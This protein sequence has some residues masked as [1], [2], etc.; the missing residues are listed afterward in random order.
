MSRR[1]ASRNRRREE[2]R[3]NSVE[4]LF[5]SSSSSSS[6]RVLLVLLASSL[7]FSLVPVVCHAAPADASG[8]RDVLQLGD[9]LLGRKKYAEAIATYSQVVESHPKEEMGFLKRS[10][11]YRRARKPDQA[12]ADL[13]AA[14]KLNGKSKQALLKRAQLYRSMCKV[15]EARGDLDALLGIKAKHKT[16]IEE[17]KRLDGLATS[18]AAL[19]KLFEARRDFHGDGFLEA[20]EQH[21]DTVFRETEFCTKAYIWYARV[22]EMKQDYEQVIRETN[23]VLQY[24]SSNIESL[25]MKA[26][27]HYQQEMFDAC[28]QTIAQIFRTDPDNE[29][30]KLLFKLVKK[31]AKI[32]SKADQLAGEKKMRQA[33]GEYRKL[34]EMGGDLNNRDI[35]KS[36]IKTLCISNHEVGKY[37]EA[38]KWC[39]RGLKTVLQEDVALLEARAESYLQQDDFDNAEYDARHILNINRHSRKAHGLIQQIQRLRKMAS[40]KDYYK[41]LEV[42]KDATESDIKKS[43][44]RLARKWHPD[45]NRD[46]VEEAQNMFHDV[47]EAYEILSDPEKKQLFDMGHDPNDPQARARNNYGFNGGGPFG[48]GGGPFGGGGQQHFHFTYG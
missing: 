6:T 18:L 39:T 22:A 28:K 31:V 1:S 33:L 5:S 4:L 2:R 45:K 29:E 24:R 37:P 10:L 7:V 11:A 20:S 25:M 46:N 12:L 44:K 47:A 27:A 13:N 36:V 14:L 43:Y 26:N 40:R 3:K 48:G 42:S 19:T 8:L 21:F 38:V 41:I 35:E 34:A 30:A 17:K 32:K 16:A 9:S 15:Q 23:S